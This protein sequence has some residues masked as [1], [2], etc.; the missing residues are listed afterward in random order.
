M[1]PIVEVNMTGLDSVPVSGVM[2]SHVRTV[3][4]NDTIQ[5]A[6]RVMIQNNIGSVIVVIPQAAANNQ[7]PIGLVTERDIVRH[8]A[9][10]PAVF[11]GHV[12][13]IMSKPII[14]IHQSSSVS[15]A[16]QLM[17]FKDIR[18]PVVVGSGANDNNKNM[19]G[20]VTDKDIFRFIAKNES[21]AS[22]FINEEVL[23]RNRDMSQHFSTSLLE[24]IIHGRP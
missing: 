14:T 24:D 8:F 4:E 1:L 22:T 12:G 13:Q 20:I 17:Q 19:I 7:I 10:T 6:C 21:V 16:L 2:T 5:Q 3:A 18:R 9:E 23:A 11:D 15:D